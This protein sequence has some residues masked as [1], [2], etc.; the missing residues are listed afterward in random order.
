[1]VTFYNILLIEDDKFYHHHLEEIFKKEDMFG[2]TSKFKAVFNLE[3]GINELKKSDYSI[4]LLDLN[5]PDSRGYET[6]EK[7]F[8]HPLCM[9]IPII[10]LTGLDDTDLAKKCV[11]NGA[12]EYLV[13]QIFSDSELKRVIMY[14][15][16]RNKLAVEKR[17]YQEKLEDLVDLKTRDIRRM[18]KFTYELSKALMWILQHDILDNETEYLIREFGPILD[19]SRICVF[20]SNILNIPDYRAEYIIDWHNPEHQIPKGISNWDYDY[21]Y[22]D[23][24]RPKIWKDALRHKTMFWEYVSSMSDENQNRLSKYNVKSLLYIPILDPRVEVWGF[25]SCMMTIDKEWSELELNCLNL[26][27]RVIAWIQNKIEIKKKEME[28]KKE[29]DSKFEQLML[30]SKENA[31]EI[32]MIS[33][34]I[35]KFVTEGKI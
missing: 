14:A 28:V 23:Q 15:I 21:S 8:K 9:D 34:R 13:K 24:R 12:Q 33:Q 25:I 29:F 19:I 22:F 18:A 26:L 27:S 4:I 2:L 17:K 6:F 1:M 35:G 5:L 16:E 31:S 7:L 11:S 30:L 10:I 3:S 32:N 20:K